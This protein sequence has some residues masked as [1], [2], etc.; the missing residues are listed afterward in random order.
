M[1][2]EIRKDLIKM[3]KQTSEKDLII[4]DGRSN[5]CNNCENNFSLYSTSE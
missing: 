2:L 3:D 1:H 4:R 5:F